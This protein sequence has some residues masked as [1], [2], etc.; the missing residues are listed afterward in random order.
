MLTVLS[1]KER[2]E[3]LHINYEI[4]LNRHDENTIHCFLQ[5]Y[6]MMLQTTFMGLFRYTPNI[7]DS[8][9]TVELI[10]THRINESHQFTL[11]SLLFSE[12]F[13]EQHIIIS[14]VLSTLN[15]EFVKVFFSAFG[16]FM[17]LFTS[18]IYFIRDRS[19]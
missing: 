1:F 5:L 12:I 18:V 16:N 8:V 11:I 4:L 17:L 13:F 7:T 2:C 19:K 10:N 15:C 9:G 3:I 14:L 6:R